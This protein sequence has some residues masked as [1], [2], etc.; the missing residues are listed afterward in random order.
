MN[1]EL[2]E[3]TLPKH[4]EQ[5]YF[6]YAPTQMGQDAKLLVSVHGLGRDARSHAQQLVPWAE[7][8]GVVL[9]AP[10]FPADRFPDY[11]FLGATGK[12]ERPD[13]VLE[14]LLA[15]ARELTGAHIERFYMHG[16][17]AGAQFGHRYTMAYPDRVVKL[18]AGAAGYYTFP[19]RGMAFPGGVLPVAGLPDISMRPEQ[20]LR[21]PALVYVGERDT[22]RT[23]SL[24]QEP[25][26]DEQQGLTRV[27]RGRR[28]SETMRSA[29]AGSGYDTEYRYVTVPDA[30]HSLAQCLAHDETDLGKQMFDF[31]F[32]G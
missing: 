6:L 27:E 22:D 30:G 10:Y 16:F 2:M 12:G 7:R 5:S 23:S 8:Y 25:G 17:S 29:A 31:L 3:R 1:G 15:D 24:N 20:F 11:Q 32:A 4:P 26:V 28:W 13:Y 18:V 19:D 14:P 21:V 9:L